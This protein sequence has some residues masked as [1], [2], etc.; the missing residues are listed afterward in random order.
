MT[1]TKNTTPAT[2][3]ELHAALSAIEATERAEQVRQTELAREARAIQAQ[4]VFD[5]APGLDKELEESGTASYQV[6]VDG[7]TAGDLNAA[8]AGYV[9]WLGSRSARA[10]ARRQMQ[11]AAATLDV[12]PTVSGELEY[13]QPPFTGFIDSNLNKAVEADAKKRVDAYLT[14][15]GLPAMDW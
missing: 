6:A 8:Y 5:A 9:G 11:S 14:A 12:S 10:H 4:A 3:D 13:R 15:A 1:A 2:A 7:A